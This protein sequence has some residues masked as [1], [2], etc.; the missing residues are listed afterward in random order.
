M[1]V[2][3]GDVGN[4]RAKCIERRFKA[5]LKLFGHVF[6]HALQRHMAWAFDHDLYVVFPCFAGQFAQGVQFGELGF[7]VGIGNAAGTQAVAEAERYVV[8]FHDFA[9]FVEMRVEE[10]FLMVGE[11][12]FRHDGAAARYDAGEAVGGHRHI[13][14]QHARVYGEIVHALFRLLD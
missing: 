5:V 2:A 10:V 8:G 4:E 1:V 7:V 11:A 6:F 3:G 12:P 9:D 13:A 14:Q